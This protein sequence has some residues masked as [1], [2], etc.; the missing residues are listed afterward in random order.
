MRTSGPA[1]PSGRRF[2]S[3]CQMVPAA[4]CAEHTRLSA[5][6]SLVAMPIATAGSQTGSPASSRAGS[7]T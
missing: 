3:T 1:L 4:V 7:A 2:A 6:A 5:L